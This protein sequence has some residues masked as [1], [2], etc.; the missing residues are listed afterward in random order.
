[1]VKK[2]CLFNFGGS[3]LKW[4]FFC[5]DGDVSGFSLSG[6]MVKSVFEIVSYWWKFDI[7]GCKV[8]GEWGNVL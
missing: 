7:F 5:V 1:M 6:V 8:K 3:G 4:K 2:K